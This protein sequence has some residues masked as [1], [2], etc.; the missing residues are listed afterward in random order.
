[1]LKVTK[2]SYDETAT[3]GYSKL[4]DISRD[5]IEYLKQKYKEAPNDPK[6]EGKVNW[7]LRALE[8]NG[9]ITRAEGDALYDYIYED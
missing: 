6:L 5:A 2:A 3:S 7:Y 4:T 9:I 8:D 1:M